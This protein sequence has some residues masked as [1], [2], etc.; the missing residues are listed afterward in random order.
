MSEKNRADQTVVIRL[1]GGLGNQMF[2]YAAA[3]GLSEKLGRTLSLDVSAFDAYKAWPYQLDVL[4]VP[5]NIYSGPPVAGPVSS[6]LIS[7]VK[8]RLYGD[9]AFRNGVYREPNFHYNSI[10]VDLSS[11]E[12]LLDGYFQSPNYFAGAEDLLRARFQPK[13]PFT[14]TSAGWAE[15]ISASNCSVSLHVRRGDYLSATASSVHA[16]LGLGYYHR[17][18][19]L[20]QDLVG[21]D[22][23]FFLFSDDPDYATENFAKSPRFH[24]VRS[25][26]SAPW[27]DMFLMANC[28]HNIIANSSYSWWAAWLNNGP[29]RRVISPAQWFTSEKLAGCNVLDLYPADWILLK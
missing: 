2:Q 20:M 10:S 5:Q 11:D 16:A 1:L 25:D 15:K 21:T 12:I 14:A 29:E 9:G 17:A 8:R 26:P 22:T 13:S 24:V 7:R 19:A 6:S 3:L 27:E 28:K 4:Q 23:D 18:I